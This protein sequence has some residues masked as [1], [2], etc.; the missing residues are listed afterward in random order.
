MA[1]GQIKQKQ[2]KIDK[3]Q[4]ESL[5]AIQCT[6]KEICDVLDVTDK[7]LNSWCKGTYN[8]GFSEISKEKKRIGKAS[9]R[10]R[11]WLLSEKNVTMAIWLGKQWLGQKDNP[12]ETNKS[13]NIVF[14]FVKS[15][16]VKDETDNG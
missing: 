5:C 9:L 6:E 15:S 2:S 16:E 7:T 10:R 14:Q 12:E 4:F 13:N 11:Q 1:K 3:R 8:K